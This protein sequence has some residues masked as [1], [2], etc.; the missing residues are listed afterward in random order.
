MRNNP[1]DELFGQIPSVVY[2]IVAEKI[3]LQSVLCQAEIS[4]LNKK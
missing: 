1:K 4:N 2:R 3:T